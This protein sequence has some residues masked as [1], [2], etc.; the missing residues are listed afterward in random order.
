MP[1]ARSPTT[2]TRRRSRRRSSTRRRRRRRPAT[3]RAARRLVART[4][5]RERR[6][7]DVVRRRRASGSLAR[8]VCLESECVQN[9]SLQTSLTPPRLYDSGAHARARLSPHSRCRYTRASCVARHATARCSL[10]FY[11]PRPHANCTRAAPP[12][13]HCA[14]DSERLL[15]RRRHHHVSSQ[16]S[17]R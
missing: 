14:R 8:P 4:V 2:S 3:R 12:C 17:Q 10:L 5:W 16:K 1:T 13:R 7:W 9:Y 6:W 11:A 15:W